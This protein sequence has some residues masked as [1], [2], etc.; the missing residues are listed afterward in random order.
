MS[1]L[2]SIGIPS[3]AAGADGGAPKECVESWPEARMQAYGYNHIVHLRDVCEMPADCVV[4]TDVN[5]EPTKVSVAA[6][7][8]TEVN[9]F[10]GSPAR[11]FTPKVVCVLRASK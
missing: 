11:V 4:T 3:L 6:K 10:L 9:T 7:S 2:A 5:P 8:E 1:L